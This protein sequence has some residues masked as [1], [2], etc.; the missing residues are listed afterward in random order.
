M[1]GGVGVSCV[2]PCQ[3]RDSA[4]EKCYSEGDRCRGA[5]AGNESVSLRKFFETVVHWCRLRGRIMTCLRSLVITTARAVALSSRR[6]QGGITGSTID[7]FNAGLRQPSHVP[8]Q[9]RV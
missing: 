2:L 6:L 1:L 5:V 8:V 3:L 4:R 9:V 7:I